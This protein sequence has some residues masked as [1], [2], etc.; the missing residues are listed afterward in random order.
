MRRFLRFV[1]R[2]ILYMLLIIAG[3]LFSFYVMAPVYEFSGPVKF[4]G[5]KLYNPYANMDPAQWKKYNFQVQS[6]AWL[7]ITNGRKNSNKLIDSVYTSLGFDHVATSDYQKINYYGKQKPS[8]IPTYE[9]GYSLAKVHQVCIDADKVLWT[10]LLLWQSLSMKQWII[11][12]L[13]KD[14]RIV[15]LAH[16]SLRNGYST[17]DLRYLTN[18][19]MLEVL[20]GLYISTGQWDAALSSG[21]LAWIL[22]DDD[23]HDVLHLD[24]TGRKFTMINAPTTGKDEI[25]TRLKAGNCYGVDYYLSE[26]TTITGKAG[27]L[28]QMPFLVRAELDGDTLTVEFSRKSREIDFIGENGTVRKIVNNVRT[29]S[30][31][32][33]PDD[34]YI[35]TKANFFYTYDLYL[36]PVVRYEGASLRSQKTAVIDADATLRLRIIYFVILLTL[37]FLF[38]KWKRKK[39]AR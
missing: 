23:T 32:M 21:Q 26:D 14:C 28:E 5:D 34:P 9:H 31:V 25:I 3:M 39:T 30:Y 6:K 24:E 15:A 10:D 7:G 4:T 37:A 2:T 1:R 16:P 36:N 19:D 12:L 8:F 17:E 20:S 38:A 29:A 33:Q 13:K 27:K 18:Y 22:A 11:D 35:R